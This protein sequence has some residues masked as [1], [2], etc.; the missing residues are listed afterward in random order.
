MTA[1]EIQ[2]AKEDYAE[3]I[4]LAMDPA[5]KDVSE[6][7][8]YIKAIIGDVDALLKK[9]MPSD[10]EIIEWAE[11]E[12]PLSLHGRDITFLINFSGKD[13]AIAGARYFHN[14]ITGKQ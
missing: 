5:Y 11:A 13:G 3:Y 1:E 2:K 10:E 7:D 4:Y 9:I 14:C 8:I 6:K 12:Y